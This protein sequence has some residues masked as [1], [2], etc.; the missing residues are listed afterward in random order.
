LI[1]RPAPAGDWT[2]APWFLDPAH[3]EKLWSI[4]YER[5]ELADAYA[6][7]SD[8]YPS[9]FCQALFRELEQVGQPAHETDRAVREFRQ[10]ESLA[11]SVRELYEPHGI[12]S[13]IL[14]LGVDL[15]L[16]LAA[17]P[18][19]QWLDRLKDP[20]GVR[21]AEFEAQVWANAIRSGVPIRRV[22]ETKSSRPGIKTP[23]FEV[24][25]N[26]WR[27]GVEAKSVETAN[28]TG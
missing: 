26:Q 8:V 25:W 9:D 20:D 17:K 10:L 24:D 1:S 22:P 27:F 2:K 19:R 6:A 12:V 15:A 28:T 11:D 5:T 14:T 4:R 3:A 16:V 23:D 21:G 7:L 13:E 18:P